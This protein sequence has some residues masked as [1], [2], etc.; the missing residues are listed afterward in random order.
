MSGSD[1]EF[2]AEFTNNKGEHMS[3]TAISK[4]LANH[5][6]TTSKR[7]ICELP[8]VIHLAINDGLKVDWHGSRDLIFGVDAGNF[9]AH[10]SAALNVD[11]VFVFDGPHHPIEK[12][13]VNQAIT[14]YD[15][16]KILIQTSAPGEAEAKLAQMNIL[17][18]VDCVLTDDSDTF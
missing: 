7:D 6:K 18:L 8:S 12:A 10:F 15:Q 9:L 16:A 5:H 1:K 4:A 3:F 11:F 2:W 17:G 13:V 14:F